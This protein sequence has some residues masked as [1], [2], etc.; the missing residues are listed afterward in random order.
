MDVNMPEMN[1]IEAAS[2]IRG[3][4]PTPVVLITASDDTAVINRAI[5]AGAMAYLVKP[6]RYEELLPAIELAILRFKEQKALAELKKENE[7]LKDALKARKLIEK[8]KG[9]LMQKERLSE[10][11]AF[12]R[13]R[14]ISMDRRKSMTEIAEIVIGAFAKD[15]AQ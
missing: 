1:G 8:A 12:T 4:C 15:K 6:V 10:D 3:L 2:E 7:G 14:R 9:I 11:E 13:L 5:E